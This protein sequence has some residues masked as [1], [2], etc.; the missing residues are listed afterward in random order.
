M[1]TEEILYHCL[2]N[3]SKY[4]QLHHIQIQILDIVIAFFSHDAS[5]KVTYGF[6]CQ[7]QWKCT[8]LIIGS[9]TLLLVGDSLI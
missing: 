3:H 2:V 4:H 6:F 5:R 9:T 7:L 1:V 8:I